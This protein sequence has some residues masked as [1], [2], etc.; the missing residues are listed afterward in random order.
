[1]SWTFTDDVDAFLETAGPSLAA[2][3]AE[4]TL[5]LTVTATL[6]EGG[7]HAYGASFYTHP[8]PHEK[9]ENTKSR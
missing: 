3:P 4:N 7:P 2:R 6:R 5:L 9:R 8:R 1:M